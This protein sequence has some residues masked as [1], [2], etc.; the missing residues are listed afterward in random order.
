MSIKDEYSKSRAIKKKVA[1]SSG[2]ISLTKKQKNKALKS[3]K[4]RPIVLVFLFVLILGAVG[5]YFAF[6]LTSGFEMLSYSINDVTSEEL[7]Y[8]VVDI[9]EYKESLILAGENKS[10]QEIYDSMVLKDDG[11]CCKFFGI[12]VKNTVKTRYM[13]RED[14]S[15]DVAEV[16]GVDIQTPGVYYI[17]YTSSHF[18]FKNKTL[19]RTIVV[20][21]VEDDG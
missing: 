4:K 9:T 16:G 18:A 3:V 19:I 14:I 11:V 7:D 13:Y 5:G 1:N 21:G 2:E 20:L 10:M 8:V 6:S 12:D 15:H 17:E